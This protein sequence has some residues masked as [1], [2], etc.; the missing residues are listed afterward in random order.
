MILSMIGLQAV[1]QEGIH[2]L[3]M[4]VK[5]LKSTEGKLRS[6]IAQHR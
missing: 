4:E 6:P 2:T 5:G 3:T 1:S